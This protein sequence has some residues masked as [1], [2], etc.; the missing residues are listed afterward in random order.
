MTIITTYQF[1]SIQIYYLNNQKYNIKKI[2]KK[3]FK[4]KFFLILAVFLYSIVI[5]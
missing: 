4:K 1:L 5:I 2:C 3:I